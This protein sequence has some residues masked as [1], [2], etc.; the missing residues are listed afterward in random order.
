[1]EDGLDWSEATYSE[2]SLYILKTGRNQEK[3]DL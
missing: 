2:I 1:M 3:L